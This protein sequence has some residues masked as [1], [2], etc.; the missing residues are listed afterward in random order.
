M[1]H[2]VIMIR[3]HR[4]SLQLPAKLFRDGEQATMQD[5][6]SLC[7]AEVMVLEIRAGGNEISS[8]L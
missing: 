2:K 8:V 5:R 6:Q 1:R 4:P 7:A 3:E